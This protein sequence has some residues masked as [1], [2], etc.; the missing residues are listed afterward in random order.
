MAAREKCPTSDSALVAIARIQLQAG[1]KMEALSALRKAVELNAS[2]KKLLQI[3]QY[4]A[5]LYHDPEFMAI[6]GAN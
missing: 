2:N 6:V 1:R 5:A 4:F 3:N